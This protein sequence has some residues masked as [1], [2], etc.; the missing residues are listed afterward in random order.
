[1]SLPLNWSL[2]AYP[3][4]RRSEGLKPAYRWTLV[5][6]TVA[7]VLVAWLDFAM[8]GLTISY[9]CDIATAVA[10]VAITVLLLAEKK[11]RTNPGVNRGVYIGAV[12]LIGVS[13]VV[14]VLLLL[15]TD[16]LFVKTHMAAEYGNI[17]NLFRF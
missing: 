10:L 16:P 2:A 12:I 6:T 7:A 1:M 5:T 9:V 17:Q 15:G 4:V 11:S 3:A 14:G 8:A 13:F